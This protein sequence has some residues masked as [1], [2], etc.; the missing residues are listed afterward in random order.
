MGTDYSEP[1]SGG[2][3]NQTAFSADNS[4]DFVGTNGATMYLTGVQA[5]VG[6]NATDFEFRSYGEELTLCQRYFYLKKNFNAKT[7][8][9]YSTTGAS[10]QF[11][12]PVEMR[13]NPT[14]SYTGT[15]SSDINFLL[16]T[17]CQLPNIHWVQCKY[18]LSTIF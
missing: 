12:F 3:T 17:S 4:V 8:W 15:L 11:E 6:T 2:W 10:C 16:W 18:C 9:L 14:F 13:A 7:M 5:E 1:V